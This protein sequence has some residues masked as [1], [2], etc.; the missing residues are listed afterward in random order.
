MPLAMKRSVKVILGVV[1]GLAAIQV[2]RFARTNPPVTRE[3]QAPAAVKTV[4]RRS[5][6]D[7]HSNEVVWPWYSG[8]APFSWLTHRDVSEGRRHL[9]FSTWGEL[10][11][12]RR[13]KKQHEIAE[14][15]GDGGMPLWFYLPLHAEARLSATDKTLL[16]E[17][18]KG[19][20][21]D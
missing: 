6:W 21:A 3:I 18:A 13:A 19:P 12:Q 9:N 1:V 15:V 14:E 10:D 4:L 8:V 5:C 20:V 16:V 7:C 11:P 2:V 17:W